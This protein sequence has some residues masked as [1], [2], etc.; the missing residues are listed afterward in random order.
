[1]QQ[2]QSIPLN[3]LPLP[4]QRYS[5]HG[6]GNCCRDFT[7]QL[8]EEDLEK[9]RAQSWERSLGDVTV[10]FRGRKFLAQRPDGA[11][12]FLLDDGKCRIH[13]E[14][15]LEAKPLAC[16]LFPFNFAP[17]AAAARVGISFACASVLANQGASLP[18]HM[19]EIRRMANAVTELTPVR[20]LLDE[21][22][23]ATPEELQCVANALDGWIADSKWPLAVRIDGLAWLGQ[24]L[25]GAR[26]SKVRGARLKEL[27]ETLISALPQELPLHPV[28]PATR[29]Q[30]ATLRQA[31][32]FRLED[33]K[34]GELR[35]VGRVRAILGQYMR[36]RAF[37][38]G[39]G[40]MPAMGDRWPS[41]DFAAIDQVQSLLGSIEWPACEEL[42]VRWMR[43][44]ILGGRAWGSGY[45]GWSVPA[46]IQ[47]LAL[48]VACAC[49]LSRAHAAA[50]GRQEP[51][52]E[53]VR[54]AIGRV[55]R[56]CG[57]AP[58]IGSRAES[59]RMGFLRVDDGLRRVAAYA[60][61]NSD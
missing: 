12:V 51:L 52:L 14:F 17:D 53:D 41:A 13:A 57:R 45:Y 6:C 54:A 4:V 47:A 28:D 15:G 60:L 37:A 33:P 39:V 40:R 27:M 59:M 8:R 25:S 38:K 26:F 3:I 9:L 24:Q 21:A 55:D 61:V 23:E 11:C 20:T 43:A 1:M 19:P 10:E 7:V 46:G 44:T 22:T 18:S 31:A 35:R 50:S 2:S 58:W 30:Q 36:S 29:A 5:C 34:I 56:S 42:L 16:Q 48:N 32:F 49:W